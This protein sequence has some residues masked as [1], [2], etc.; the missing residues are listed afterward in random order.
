[1]NLSNE[2]DEELKKLR[3][4]K[5]E[6][7]KQHMQKPQPKKSRDVV[8]LN[9]RNFYEVI[10]KANLSIVDLWAD[11]CMPCKIMEPILKKLAT[12]PEYGS[13]FVFCSLNA[14]EN[15]QILQRYGV[16]GIPTFLIFARGKLI[17]KIVGAVGE[18]GLRNA[19]NNILRKFQSK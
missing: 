4:K 15:P 13:K 2:E 19:L 11:W 12:T 16:M 1:M 18:I 14:D 10:N 7:L 9:S 5:M 8:I 17:D 3:L 6:E